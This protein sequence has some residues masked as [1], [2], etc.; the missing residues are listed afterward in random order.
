MGVLNTWA[1]MAVVKQCLELSLR[2]IWKVEEIVNGE[3]FGF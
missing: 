1:F 2:F 3:M